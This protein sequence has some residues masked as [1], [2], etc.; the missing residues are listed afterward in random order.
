LR[1]AASSDL[2]D[3]V[4]IKVARETAGGICAPIQVPL[5]ALHNL[6]NVDGPLTVGV[7]ARRACKWLLCQP[8]M[9]R[10]VARARIQWRLR[11]CHIL[12]LL[13]HLNFKL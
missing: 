7:S 12:L 4:V 1:E 5:G 3:G 2:G 11:Q 10:V 6:L 8:V 9:A 13:H